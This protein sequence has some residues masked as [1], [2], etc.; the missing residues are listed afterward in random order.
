MISIS[1]AI[2]FAGIGA[3]TGLA[4]HSFLRLKNVGRKSA[5][6]V[7]TIAGLA[8]GVVF[9]LMINLLEF[10]APAVA[11]FGASAFVLLSVSNWRKK[12]LPSAGKENSV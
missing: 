10:V 8:G 12:R 1:E 7:C 4:G 9:N 3:A 11:A 6:T 5:L 2:L